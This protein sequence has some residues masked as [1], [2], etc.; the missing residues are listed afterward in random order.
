MTRPD[1]IALRLAANR[2]SGLDL[3]HFQGPTEDDG[4][5]RA[6]I[7]L[8]REWL[9]EHP[10][11]VVGFD[12]FWGIWPYKSGKADAL[13]A[14]KALR[15][16]AET[17][18]IIFADVSARK[19]SPAWTKNGGEFIPLPASYLRGRRWED[20]AVSVPGRWA[21][22]RGNNAAADVIDQAAA[23]IQAAGTGGTP[24]G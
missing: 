18:A 17:R 13:K 20:E 23:A 3:A 16:S 12:D 2:L 10:E 22:P 5:M 8:A 6:G 9:R 14:W 19:S 1:E 21:G 4:D 15:P 11:A 7:M 24:L